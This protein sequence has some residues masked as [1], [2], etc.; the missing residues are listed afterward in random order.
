MRKSRIWT[1]GLGLAAAAAIVATAS[2]GNGGHTKTR[3]SALARQVT[4]LKA[5]NTRLHD[6]FSP[7]GIARQLEKT[8][9]AL[10]KYQSVDAA[11]QA[12]YAPASPCEATPTDPDQSSYGGGMGVHFVNP[13]LMAPGPLDPA[14]PPILVYAPVAGGG[15][16]LVAAEYFKPDADQNVKTDDDRP[17]LFGRA[18][19]GPMLGHAPGMPIHYD[20]HVWLWQHN[21]SGLF[22]PWNPDVTC[23]S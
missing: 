4:M 1:L 2:A 18:F 3:A 8:K 22:A 15:F 7:A 21:P 10:D 9:A 5:Q 23:P 19:D 20:L 12:G 17:S 11:K 16:R 13:A 14:K 6:R